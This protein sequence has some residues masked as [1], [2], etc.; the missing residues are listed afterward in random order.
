MYRKFYNI[1]ENQLVTNEQLVQEFITKFP[2]YGVSSIFK[3]F[4]RNEDL[5]HHE[6]L[7]IINFANKF[8]TCTLN[9]SVLASKTED[10]KLKEG[11]IDVVMIVKKCYIHSHTK[12][13][14]KYSSECRFRFAKFPMWKTILTRTMKDKG[15]DCEAVKTKLNNILKKVKEL[16][17]DKDVIAKILEEIP[18]DKDITK[19]LYET[20]RKKRI[21]KVL[22]LAGLYT[23]EEIQ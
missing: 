2:L 18:K 5:L 14:K 13:C 17:N 1:E 6:E 4:Q 19:E 20:N 7:A 12:S 3:K 23:D 9:E 10:E 22:N 16:I 21:V 11:S 8:T 15:K